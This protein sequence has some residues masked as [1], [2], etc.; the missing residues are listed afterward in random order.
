MGGRD[1]VV[2]GICGLVVVLM[3]GASYAAVPF[4]NWF[5]RTTGF[6][7][8]TQ[9]ATSAPSAAQAM[10]T[11]CT[12]DVRALSATATCA[13]SGRSDGDAGAEMSSA[14]SAPCPRA[15]AASWS[16]SGSPS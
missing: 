1:A 12:C 11:H 16:A 9:V 4:Y 6:N 13:N 5:C 8:T 7:G 15:I 10:T 2:A 14:R 3:V